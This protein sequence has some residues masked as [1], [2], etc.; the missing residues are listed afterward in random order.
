MDLISL[1]VMQSRYAL[2]SFTS[3]RSC[4]KQSRNSMCTVVFFSSTC[5]SS[6]STMINNLS[7]Y[8]DSCANNFKYSSSGGVF[9]PLL[10]LENNA[11]ASS[12]IILSC[13]AACLTKL[14]IKLKGVCFC[15]SLKTQYTKHTPTC[16]SSKNCWR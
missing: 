12:G 8:L 4:C 7:K 14:A 10:C 15:R 13:D 1:E 3:S 9:S 5:S 2:E 16:P 6:A 11:F